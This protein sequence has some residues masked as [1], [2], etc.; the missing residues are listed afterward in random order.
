MLA[1]R[2]AV[3]RAN[4]HVRSKCRKLLCRARRQ[5][6][7]LCCGSSM[8]HRTRASSCVAA[9]ARFPSHQVTTFGHGLSMLNAFAMPLYGD[10][11]QQRTVDCCCQCKRWRGA[12]GS[13]YSSSAGGAGSRQRRVAGRTGKRQAV[14]GGRSRAAA[15]RLWRLGAAGPRKWC[16][17]SVQWQAPC[18]KVTAHC[19]HHARMLQ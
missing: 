14:T 7:R 12:R 2:A 5:A 9:W 10:V 3:A 13:R 8:R 18:G 15:R 17:R 4:S 6:W 16:R 19:Q 1:R 11:F